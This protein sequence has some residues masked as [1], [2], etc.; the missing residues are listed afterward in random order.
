M[1]IP[2]DDPVDP[3]GGNM[4]KCDSVHKVFD[5]MLEKGVHVG[6]LPEW[7]ALGGKVAYRGLRGPK[8]P[9]PQAWT[10]FRSEAMDVAQSRPRGRPGDADLCGPVDPRD[11]TGEMFTLP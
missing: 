8:E 11:V 1:K 5:S 4:A 9:L 7:M 3:T 2:D 6:T 10:E